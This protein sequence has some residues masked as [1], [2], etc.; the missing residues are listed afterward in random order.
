MPWRANSFQGMTSV[1][2]P[3]E[4]IV[5]CVSVHATAISGSFLVSYLGDGS[6][7]LRIKL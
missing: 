1:R 2:V 6:W 5:S 3:G 7:P 4:L